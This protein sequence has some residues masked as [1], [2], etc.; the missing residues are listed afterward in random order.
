[1]NLTRSAFQSRQ[2]SLTAGFALFLVIGVAP[3]V[4]MVAST[5]AGA[6]PASL[7]SSLMTGRQWQLLGHTVL[8]GALV[9]LCTTL[10]G[11]PLGLVLAKTDLPYKGLLYSIL[12]VPLFLPPYLLALSWFYLLGKRDCW[13][14]SPAHSSGS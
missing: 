3:V 4:W 1:M 10:V 13:P 8:L 7:L 6:G 5:F 14:P 11:T 9:V 12:T 2:I